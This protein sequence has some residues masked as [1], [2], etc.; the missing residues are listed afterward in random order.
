MPPKYEN[1]DNLLLCIDK[2]IPKKNGFSEKM[3]PF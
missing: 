2:S 1:R 3:F